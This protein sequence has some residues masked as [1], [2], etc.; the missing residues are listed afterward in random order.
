MELLGR[1]AHADPGGGGNVLELASV[2]AGEPW[3]NRPRSVH[4]ALAAVAEV[5]NDLLPDDRRPLIT[6]L[7]AWLAGTGTR[8]ARVW[9][10]LT[11]VCEQAV[12]S[13]TGQDQPDPPEARRDRRRLDRALRS[14]RLSA[15]SSVSRDDADAA[16]CQV[17]VDC[18][19]EC[20]RL[21]GEPAVDPR[22]PLADC[23]RRLSVRPRVMRSP[24]CDWIEIGYEPVPAQL[25]ACLLRDTA[26]ATR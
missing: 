25:P 9:P 3:S 1:G 15:A 10:A 22:L 24:G 5:V 16:L 4:P 23:P 8:D 18:I 11:R 14:L 17:L 6:P 2:L 7:A 19:N 21:A 20:R 12:A 13:I 26:T